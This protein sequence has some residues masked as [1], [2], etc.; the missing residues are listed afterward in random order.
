MSTIIGKA[1][2]S[3]ELI[4][5]PHNGEALHMA[6]KLPHSGLHC[7]KALALLGAADLMSTPLAETLQEA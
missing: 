7:R 4:N 3:V 2:S 5:K 6:S 1:F